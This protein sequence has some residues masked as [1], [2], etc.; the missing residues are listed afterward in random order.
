VVAVFGNT[1]DYDVACNLIQP[2]DWQV[3]YNLTFSYDNRITDVKQGGTTLGTFVYDADGNRVL[4]TV[5]GVTTAY[6][7]GLFCQYLRKL[8]QGIGRE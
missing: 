1:R 6:V 4:G 8:S 3:L 5:A 2:D 7:A